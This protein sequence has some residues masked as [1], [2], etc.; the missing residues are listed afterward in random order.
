MNPNPQ[1][2]T[3]AEA[4][5]RLAVYGPN[6]V[7]RAREKSWLSH[8]MHALADPMVGL[9]AGI[10][11]INVFVGEMHDALF[12]IFAIGPIAA[13]DLALEARGR[14][15]LESLRTLTRRKCHVLRDNVWRE[16]DAEEMVPGDFVEVREGDRIAADGDLISGLDLTM[17]ES[18]L[19]GESEPVA[20]AVDGNAR[21]FAGSVVASGRGRFLVTQTGAAT[22]FG[23]IVDLAENAPQHPTPMQV[24]L[25]HL[26]RWLLSGALIACAAV[27]LLERWHG[28]S[29]TNAA[30]AGLTLAIAAV[31][32]EFPV[33]YALFLALGAFRLAA[34]R[35]LVRNLTAVET[36]G[37][38]TVICADKTGTLTQG[39]PSLN[40]AVSASD[41]WPV[42]SKTPSLEI[43]ELLEA[44]VLASEAKPFDPLEQSIENAAVVTGI[45]VPELRRKY[46]ILREHPFEPKTKY[47]SHVC[48][49]GDQAWTFSKG[50]PETI[51][52]L[53]TNP[54]MVTKMAAC[55]RDGNGLRWLA[56]AR[57]E[58]PLEAGGRPEDE[59]HL[60]VLG[61]LG[62]QDPLREESRDAVQQCRRA[63]VRVVMITGDHKSTAEVIARQAGIGNG[64]P[65]IVTL[66]EVQGFSGRA[67]AEVCT[68]VDGFARATP[69]LKSRIVETLIGEGEVVAMTGDGVN[70]APALKTAHIGIAMGRRGTEAARDSAQLVLSD[71]SF[72]SFVHAIREGRKA[73]DDIKAAFRYLLVFHVPVVAL[74]LIAPAVGLPLILLTPQI[75]WLELIVHPTVSI[76]F[77]MRPAP[78]DLLDQPPRPREEGLFNLK[79]VLWAMMAGSILTTAPAIS[80]L[81]AQASNADAARTLAMIALAAGLAVALLIDQSQT[82][83]RNRTVLPIALGT[84]LS[85]IPI[86]LVPIARELFHVALPAFSTALLS[87][88]V[89]VIAG[90]IS[91]TLLHESP[92][93]R[94]SYKSEDK[95]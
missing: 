25:S 83:R 38:A 80:F 16:L 30:G 29:W 44:A 19:T 31:P 90:I 4:I 76:V 45:V 72:A 27:A 71:D 81:S 58:A 36:L 48:R 50:A 66:Q 21:L 60:R 85:P 57:A 52:S 18:A 91:A 70:D 32:E 59:R 39:F 94:N 75:I 95:I 67:F 23:R 79:D 86:L 7:R 82:T 12:V 84:L 65:R 13:L 33:V 15:A 92:D 35:V 62:F 9:L 89:G 43:L 63:G 78:T 51:F 26:V 93:T 1:G 68:T 73:F 53:A 74:A 87:A 37:S 8:V 77:P 40:K 64:S 56:V 5:K 49:R 88:G 24:R 46:E 6:A 47:H 61:A 11:I 69:E 55:L 34:R 54:D 42:D 2:L 14:R 28:Q 10:G 22:E 41:I 20:K 17:D 3:S